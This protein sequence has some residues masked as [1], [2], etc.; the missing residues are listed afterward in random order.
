[1][2]KNKFYILGT[3]LLVIFTIFSYWFDYSIPRCYSS[4]L[5]ATWV[6]WL[7][8]D[9]YL[10]KYFAGKWTI[11]LL[12]A[13]KWKGKLNSE[14]NGGTQKEIN[15]IIRQTYSTIVIEV[16]TDQMMSCSICTYCDKS[17][18]TY[19]H[20]LYIYR[21][22]PLNFDKRDNLQQYGGGK[23]SFK[24]ENN[25]IINYWTT[26]STRGTIKLEKIAN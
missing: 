26:S 16:K 1:M 5:L 21:T 25:L 8:W 13:G 4:S 6:I 11:P 15:I 22:Y 23:L 17:F 19:P 14:Y 24:D 20:L 3:I 18:S 12:I 9:F 2:N 7:T 10:W